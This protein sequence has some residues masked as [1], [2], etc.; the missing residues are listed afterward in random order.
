MID[1]VSVTMVS[2]GPNKKPDM[3]TTDIMKNLPSTML[4]LAFTI[5]FGLTFVTGCNRQ[6]IDFNYRFNK[7]I[8]GFPDGTH[9]VVKIKKW[10]D[11]PDG[12]QIQV[13]AEDGT[14]YLGHS[15]N[16]LLIKENQ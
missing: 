3:K 1:T 10:T 13:I 12:D 5:V 15:M 14:V 2:C 9:K 6:V 11:F 16:I 4:F 7:A 8:V